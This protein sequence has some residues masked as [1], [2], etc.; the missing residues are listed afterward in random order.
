MQNCVILL[1]AY[2][3]ICILWLHFKLSTTQ[4]F[5]FVANTVEQNEQYEIQKNSAK[6]MVDTQEIL[7]KAVDH[8]AIVASDCNSFCQSA[9]HGNG[10][11]IG[12]APFC[13]G[14]CSSDCQGKNCMDWPGNCWTG[15]K[16]CCCS[17]W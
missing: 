5:N 15:N 8:D 1:E 10:V 2:T 16:I 11:V 6:T 12:T 3:L 7:A 9:G 14:D 17:Q 13:A 4:C